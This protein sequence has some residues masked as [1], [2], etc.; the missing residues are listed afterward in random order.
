MS[1]DW[2]YEL[3][4]LRNE[5]EYA[6]ACKANRDVG[7]CVYDQSYWFE[8]YRCLT[9]FVLPYLLKQAETHRLKARFSV[10]IRAKKRPPK[11]DAVLVNGKSCAYLD[12][13]FRSDA[14]RFC[15]SENL[16]SAAR[17][18]EEGYYPG[19][20]VDHSGT[21]KNGDTKYVFTLRY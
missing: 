1:D 9:R 20:T 12:E 19:I 6:V 8:G 10:T 4:H 14:R 5:H 21:Y 2:A 11:S 13:E 16:E 17:T 15:H 3:R 18:V 7:P